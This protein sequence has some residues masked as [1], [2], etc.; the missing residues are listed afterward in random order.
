MHVANG[1]NITGLGE[2]RFWHTTSHIKKLPE[3]QIATA[4]DGWLELNECLKN[5]PV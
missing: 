5:S 1:L 4:V 3:H 2:K